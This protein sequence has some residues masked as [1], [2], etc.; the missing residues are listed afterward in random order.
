V[1]LE[2]LAT[3]LLGLA[4]VLLA[5]RGQRWCWPVGAA[6]AALL[7]WLS[8]ASNLPLQ[9]GLQLFYIVLAVQGWRHWSASP[10]VL[11]VERWSLRRQGPGLVL[12]VAGAAAL[13]PLQQQVLPPGSQSAWPWLDALTT[14]FSLW[15]TWLAA[16]AV[17]E[18]WLYWVVINVVIT[19]LY[20]AQGLPW[21]ALLFVLYAVLA[22]EGWRRW[23]RLLAP[24]ESAAAAPGTGAT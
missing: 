21:L 9:A 8:W 24:L 7:G 4:Y 10:G 23:R 17:L 3:L 22:V 2:E 1:N 19:G 18:N 12:A 6:S 5:L 16:R 14:S 15:A 13:V 20:L 11:A